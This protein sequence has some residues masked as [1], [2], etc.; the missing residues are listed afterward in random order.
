SNAR[1][2]KT[3]IETRLFPLQQATLNNSNAR[4]IKTRIEA[5]YFV[6]FLHGDIIFVN[7]PIRSV[8][9]YILIVE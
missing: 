3:R 9:Y 8:R 2:I 7:K 1:S 4:S 6:M 5:F